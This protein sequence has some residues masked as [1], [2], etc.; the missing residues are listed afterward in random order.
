MA[1]RYRKQGVGKKATLG[2]GGDVS[3][4]GLIDQSLPNSLPDPKAISDARK[5]RKRHPLL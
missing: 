4:G 3:L 5:A 1:A 2:F